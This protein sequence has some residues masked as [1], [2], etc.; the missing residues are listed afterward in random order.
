[1]SRR[2]QVVDPIRQYD[3]GV[4]EVRTD[5]G[6]RGYLYVKLDDSAWSDGRRD[7][8]VDLSVVL[9]AASTA[10]NWNFSDRSDPDPDDARSEL[11]SGV[12]E[13]YGE[14]LRV[15]RWLDEEEARSVVHEHFGGP[16]R[17]AP[18]GGHNERSS[19]KYDG[20][21]GALFLNGNKVGVLFREVQV[22]THTQ[23]P[24]FR[25]S[26]TTAPRLAWCVV[27][28]APPFLPGDGFYESADE[29]A[30][31]DRGEFVYAGAPYSVV[32]LDPEE[33]ETE[34]TKF[35]PAG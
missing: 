20:A 23:G 22:W 35:G 32:W 24:L 13:W 34:R 31:L 25:R 29:I 11:V 7:I 16:D 2:K 3:R 17:V 26:K 10:S 6:G 33:A 8:G 14:V 18:R 1:M 12:I 9:Q 21:V 19:E 5:N 4:P 15:H 30:E 28:V 27:F